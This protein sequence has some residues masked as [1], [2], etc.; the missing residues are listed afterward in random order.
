MDLIMN[1]TRPLP[2]QFELHLHSLHDPR[3]EH[4]TVYPLVQVL[5]MALCSVLANC[6]G[7]DMMA[8]FART[9]RTWF[10]QW[11][12]LPKGTPSADTFRR[13]FERLKPHALTE[14]FAQWVDSLRQ[15][16]QGEVLAIDGKSVRGAFDQASR[17]TPLHLLH[18]WATE[19]KILL[20]QRAVAGAPGEIAATEELLG[21]LDIQG[22][23]VTVDA[24]GCTQGF[25]KKVMEQGADYVMA[26]KGNR[27]SIHTH[28]VRAFE[29]AESKPWHTDVDKG[30]GRI[31]RRRIRVLD[32]NP[33]PE[34][35]RRR[36]TALRTLIQIERTRVIG[37]DSSTETHY[38]LSSLPP[39]AKPIL[40]VIR[41]HWSVENQLHWVLDVSMGEDACRVR[42]RTSAEN[43]AHLRRLALTLLNRPEAGT[44]SIKMKQRKAGW[45]EDYLF[46]LLGFSTSHSRNQAT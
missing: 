3:N 5:F 33:L 28:T 38:Y 27:A 34:S 13:V 30:H 19:Q 24:N 22:A 6:E 2:G 18:V 36:W 31:E 20:G 46:K 29:Q 45:S 14:A 42:D 25:A 39:D 8:E 17:T 32:A 44:L 35:V 1:P 7:W 21:M 12:A 15:G 4:R 11:F 16:V 9:R 23:I 26:L 10:E 37:E 40:Q 41:T 43:L